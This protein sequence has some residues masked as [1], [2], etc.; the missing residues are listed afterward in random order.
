MTSKICSKCFEKD[1]RIA[2]LEAQVRGLKARLAQNSTNSSRPPSSDG[3]NKRAAIPGSQRR[4]SGKKPGGQPGHK[5][6]TLSPVQNPDRIVSHEVTLCDCGE[7]LSGLKPDR[8]TTSQVFDLPPLKIEVIEH[9][10]EVKTCPCCH[11]TITA[12]R[13]AGLKGLPVEYGP[14]IKSLSIYLMAQ[15]LIPCRRVSELLHELYGIEVSIGSLTQWS[16]EAFHG[17][18]DFETAVKRSLAGADVV[19]FDETGMRCSGHLHWLHCASTATHSFF[20]IHAE[21]GSQAMDDFGILTGFLGIALHDYWKPYLKFA[22][23]LHAFCNAHILRELMFLD[24]ELGEP[25]ARRMRQLL[26]DIHACV[27]K[28]KTAGLK[29]ISRA[30]DRKFR[31]DYAKILRAGLRFHATHDPVFE[32]G[33]RGRTKQTKGKNLL[34]RLHDFQTEV[35]RFMNDFRVPFTNNQGEQDIRM[36]KVKQKISG[37]F[38]S[39]EG[40]QIF[41]R[42][43]SYLSTAHKQGANLRDAIRAVFLGAPLPLS[44]PP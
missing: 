12:P 22:Q 2:G 30:A 5:G 8:T 24:E 23:C 36:N 25:W 34:D 39:F 3:L 44:H 18:T 32:R 21:R 7:D 27:K 26:L 6:V 41:C 31:R 42:I 13:P 19:H 38:R 1:N 17:L 20:G 28:T 16:V 29:N 15:Q 37:C 4:P 43:R 9:R 33:A 14:Q 10:F 40:A 35:L 11:R